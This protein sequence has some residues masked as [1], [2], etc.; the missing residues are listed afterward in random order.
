MPGLEFVLAI[1]VGLSLGLTG[2]GGS[3]LAVPILVYVAGISPGLSTAYSLFI[4]GATSLVGAYDF[5]QKKLLDYKTG[6]AFAIPSFITV[7]VT[8]KFLVSYIPQKLSAWGGFTLTKDMLIMLVFALLMMTASLTMIRQTKY[9]RSMNVENDGDRNF[10]YILWLGVAVGLL[11]GFAGAG[12]GFLI[13]PALVLFAGLPMKSA[14]GTSLLI[15][16][17]NSLIGFSGDL[18]AGMPINWYY[19]LSFSCFAFS[20]IIIGGYLSRFIE[21]NKL[22]PMFGWFTL[23]VGVAIIL[24]ELILK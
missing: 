15:I 7:F 24:K 3:I 11:T 13:I 9:I 8:R 1:F 23:T 4:V 12:G 17:I 20:G 14:V 22:K 10:L 6:L 18:I 21:G 2:G 19:L 16:A 5:H